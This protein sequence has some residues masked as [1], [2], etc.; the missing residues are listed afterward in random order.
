VLAS[1]AADAQSQRPDEVSP[2]ITA[3]ER[4]LE[5]IQRH[6]PGALDEPVRLIG[7]WNQ[8]QLRLIWMDA[9]TIVSLIR[10]PGVALFYV[11][12]STLTGYD[13]RQVSPIATR[14][15]QQVLY[16][17]GELQRLRE[18]AKALSPKGEPGPEND[19]L[20]RAAMLHA[21]VEIFLSRT[22][23]VAASD[24]RPGPAGATLFMNDGQQTGLSNRVS[25]WNMGRR[26][27]E[28]VRPLDSR[29][30]LKTRPDPGA[31]DT[32]RRWYLAGMAY[33]LRTRFIEL[34]HFTRASELFRDD[35]EV[36]FFAASAHE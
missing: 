6:R 13:V 8:E 11:S 26:L 10:E 32:V 27:L 31:D 5:S 22:T 35:P 25:H 3:F 36:L 12:E 23:G 16:G 20:K 29:R 33:M 14:G 2:R 4:W 15:S 24:I 34:A 28:R 17:P 19:M 7:S 21:D 1:T 30:G 9:L 18:L